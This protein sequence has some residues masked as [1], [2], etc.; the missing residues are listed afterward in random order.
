MTKAAEV[1]DHDKMNYLIAQNRQ[2]QEEV[3]VLFQ[4]QIDKFEYDEILKYVVP[5]QLG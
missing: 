4:E 5:D 1:C 3:A 2:E